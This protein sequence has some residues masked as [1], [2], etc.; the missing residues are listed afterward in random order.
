MNTLFNRANLDCWL[1]LSWRKIAII[2]A[3]WFLSVILHNLI[4]DLFSEQMGGGDEVFFFVV[5]VVV[6]PGYFVVAGV[7]T[8][9]SQLR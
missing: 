3:V 4:Y 6:I 1:H 2:A 8:L 9:L 7:Y 5:A